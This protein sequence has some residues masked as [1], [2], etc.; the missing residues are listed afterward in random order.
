[1][2]KSELYDALA[3]T[4]KALSSGK[5]LEM[6]E[7]LAQSERAEGRIECG[8]GIFPI[9]CGITSAHTAHGNAQRKS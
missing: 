9:Y 8:T 3:R 5:R 7:L 1:M 2:T 6:L 4:G